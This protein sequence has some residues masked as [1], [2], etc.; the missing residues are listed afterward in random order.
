ML[1]LASRPNPVA[2][3]IIFPNGA[4]NELTDT[5][6]DNWRQITEYILRVHL[7]VKVNLV[8]VAVSHGDLPKRVIQSQVPYSKEPT[9]LL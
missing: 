2:L 5:I 8:G 9:E 7:L 6:R 3:I 4:A 1:S